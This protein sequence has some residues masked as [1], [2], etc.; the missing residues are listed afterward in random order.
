MANWRPG[1]IF[2]GSVTERREEAGLTTFIY[3]QPKSSARS[4]AGSS[5]GR[6]FGRRGCLSSLE[7]LK[8]KGF[9]QTSN[10]ST[11]EVNNPLLLAQVLRVNDHLAKH[12]RMTSQVNGSSYLLWIG[13]HHPLHCRSWSTLVDGQEDRQR[14]LAF[15]PWLV[16]SVTSVECQPLHIN[17]IIMLENGYWKVPWKMLSQY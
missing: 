16:W 3:S 2:L 10:P 9:P 5:A 12:D 7:E 17:K 11:K 14:H 13:I 15:L 4:S 1:Y 8:A 6:I